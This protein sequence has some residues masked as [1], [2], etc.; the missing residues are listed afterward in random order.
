MSFATG[1]FERPRTSGQASNKGP[2]AP[3][4]ADIQVGLLPP[5]INKQRPGLDDVP[6]PSPLRPERRFYLPPTYQIDPTTKVANPSTC[7]ITRNSTC[8]LLIKPA[9]KPA[10]RTIHASHH[11]AKQNRE[12]AHPRP[13][14]KRAPCREEPV[15]SSPILRQAPIRSYTSPEVN[16]RPDLPRF[17][18]Q[19]PIVPLPRGT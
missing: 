18:S 11:P 3:L 5:R 4:P 6:Q 10:I 17:A 13:P 9:L 19:A 16:N 7:E 8:P 15:G 2:L 14:L 1:F 12:S